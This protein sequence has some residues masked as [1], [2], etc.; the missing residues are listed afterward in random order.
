LNH[1]VTDRHRSVIQ[2]FQV[3]EQAAHPFQNVVKRIEAQESQQPISQRTAMI[4]AAQKLI[5]PPE[6]SVLVLGSPVS[7]AALQP[8]LE[9]H[10]GSRVQLR[11]G[12]VTIEGKAYDGPGVA[13]LI[14]C[15]R[16]D[17]PGSVVTSL[18]AVSP[19][20]A[21][22]VARLLFFYGW[23]SVVVFQD[24]KAIARSEFEAPEARMEVSIDAAVSDR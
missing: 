14:S 8:V 3:A 4:P 21:T 18:Y 17:H 23:N 1:Y 7:R 9:S 24:G 6:G 12:G 13:A 19:Q 15:H 2:A 16:L 10:C 5:L 20:A 11:E 22:T